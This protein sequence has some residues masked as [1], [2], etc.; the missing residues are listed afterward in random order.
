M[1][2]RGYCGDGSCNAFERARPA[3]PR[4]AVNKEAMKHKLKGVALELN[5]G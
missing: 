3:L 2:Q 5:S 1:E 4:D